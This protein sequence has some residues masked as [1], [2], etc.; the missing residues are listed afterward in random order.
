MLRYQ[1]NKNK[2]QQHMTQSQQKFYWTFER[3]E[4]VFDAEFE[5]ANQALAYA[6]QVFLEE[7]QDEGVGNN[8]TRSDEIYLICYCC[9]DDGEIKIDQRMRQTISCTGYHGDITEHGTLYSGAGGVL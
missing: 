3:N 1:Y 5:T 2:G 7:C 4:N 6:N 8:E 9:D